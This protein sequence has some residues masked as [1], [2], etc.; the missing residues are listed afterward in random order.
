MRR[1][2]VVATTPVPAVGRPRT[3]SQRPDRRDLANALPHAP[4]R[5]TGLHLRFGKPAPH[6]CAS[7]RDPGLPPTPPRSTFPHEFAN[8]G[9]DHGR[10]ISRT[11]RHP[12]GGGRHCRAA[13]SAAAH[14]LGAG[15]SACRHADR[16]VRPRLHLRGL[17]ARQHPPHRRA[18]RRPAAVPDRAR[19][20]ARAAVGHAPRHLR[21]GRGSGVRH[22]RAAGAGRRALRHSA[23]DRRR[24]GPGAR[25][26]L[27]GVRASVAGREAGAV[28]AARAPG[29]LHPAVPGPRRHSA[30]CPCA[31]DGD[32]RRHGPCRSDAG[33]SQGGG[34]DRGGGDRRALRAQPALSCWSPHPACA[35]P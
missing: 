23:A 27:D 2:S 13:G 26:V 30:D 24:G 1:H 11:G 22:R 33:R 8:S 34:R 10:Q 20:A 7:A 5:G 19:A 6:F 14:R 9:R 16:P 4:S 12:A 17:P 3:H 28:A 18:R 35:R 29:V 15:L 32:A 25:H 21:S 31:A